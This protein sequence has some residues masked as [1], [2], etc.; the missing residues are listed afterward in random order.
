MEGVEIGRREVAQER[1]LK[2]KLE[3]TLDRKLLQQQAAADKEAAAAMQAAAHVASLQ[4]HIQHL[5]VHHRAHDSA[6]PHISQMSE[7]SWTCAYILHSK[8][9][10]VTVSNAN[11]Q[12]LLFQS[13]CIVAEF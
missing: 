1:F 2:Q 3:Q 13:A 7:S 5:K 12:C 9:R 4:Q 11:G 10:T 6:T 8:T